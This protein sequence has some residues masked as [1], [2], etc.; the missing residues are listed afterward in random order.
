VSTSLETSETY[1]LNDAPLPGKGAQ[2]WPRAVFR[3]VSACA[4]RALASLATGYFAVR[5]SAAFMA[6][7]SRIAL[8]CVLLS[9]SLTLALILLSSVPKKRD[10]HVLSV[11]SACYV[12]FYSALLDTTPGL[13][14]VPPPIAGLVAALG[15]SLMMWAKLTIGRSFGILPGVREIV[16]SGPYRFLRHPIYTGFFVTD[17]CFILTDYSQRNAMV[18]VSVAACQFYRIMRE[19]TLLRTDADYAAYCRRVPYRFIP[20]LI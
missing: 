13:S 16:V 10:W 7:P 2:S 1:R 17:I 4:P 20:G 8:L 5:A 3:C 12:Y 18:V 19:E 15:F 9:E 11:A 14:F 6:N